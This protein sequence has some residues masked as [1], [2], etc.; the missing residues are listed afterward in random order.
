M[1]RFG[2]LLRRGVVPA[3]ALITAFLAGAI[4][5]V[6]T[7]FDNLQHLGSD[8]VGALGAAVGRVVEGY[9]ALF[10][11]AIGD[12][13]KIVAAIQSGDA[14][15]IGAAIRPISET[16][17]I[18]T[19]FI[20]VG[21]GLTVSFRAGLI[22]LGADGQFA[23][24]ALG[25]GITAIV[26]GGNL[27]PVLVLVIALAGGA[28]AGAAYGYVPG[29]LKARTGAHEVITT[30]MLN[31]IAPNLVILIVRSG[32][33]DGSGS[34]IP[35]VPLIFDLPTVRVD[36]GLVAA[37][38]VAVAVSYV[39][40]RT[41]LG[42]ELRAVGFS[43]SAARGAGMRTGAATMLAMALSGGLVGL[44]SAFFQLGPA[45]GLGGAPT[46]NMGYVALA[47]ALI[48]GLRPSGVVLMA[49][50]FGALNTGAKNMVIATGIPLALLVVIIGF[51]MLF[52]AA[53][54]LTRKIWRLP[55]PT[56]TAKDPSFG[57]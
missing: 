42:F 4:L 33:F 44:G 24:G 32:I 6:L 21:L 5:I 49:L 1:R 28:L 46:A 57:T 3:L 40:F 34:A 37:L 11:G 52:V 23:I 16:L 18:T 22:N 53:P 47:L 31:V 20:F 10:S 39:L 12:P 13:G 48:A 17:L 14:D 27:P 9:G 8:P 30:L 2:E 15:H 29:L 54:S 51:A 55:P 43:P 7:D 41:T 45:S 19:P 25:A 26:I 36:Y 56:M 38:V 50:F 35:K